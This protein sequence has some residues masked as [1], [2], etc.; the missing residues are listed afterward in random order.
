MSEADVIASITEIWPDMGEHAGYTLWQATA[1][2]LFEGDDP[3]SYWL[4]QIAIYVANGYREEDPWGSDT[5]SCENCASGSR[6]TIS[7]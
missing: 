4:T 1:F 7:G 5:S 2:P 6:P 3:L